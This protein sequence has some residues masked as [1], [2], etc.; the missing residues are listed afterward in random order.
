MRTS[1]PPADIPEE[2]VLDLRAPKAAPGKNRSRPST[3]EPKGGHVDFLSMV[4]KGESALD[5]K[6]KSWFR[7]PAKVRAA[8]TLVAEPTPERVQ[9]VRQVTPEPQPQT[10]GRVALPQTL[11]FAGAV[12]VLVVAVFA[13]RFLGHVQQAKGD[14][15]GASTEAIQRL[16]AAGSAAQALQFGTTKTE[17]TAAQDAFAAAEQDLLDVAGALKNLPGAGAVRS[18]EKLLQAGQAVT[19]AASALADGAAVLTSADDTRTPFV[20]V[21]DQLQTSLTPAVKDLATAAAL[22]QGVRP[23]DLPAD[24]Q[25][26][27]TDLQGELPALQVQF[28]RLAN[29]GGFFQGFLATDGS[30]RRYLFAFQNTNELR[31]TGGF[32]GSVAIVEVT[33]GAITK[34]EVPS[35]GIYD[36]S[37]QTGLRYIA[38]QPLQLVQANWNL[39]DANWFPDFPTSAKKILAFYASTGQPP[40]D[41]IVAVTPAVLQSFLELTGPVEVPE[42][43]L[44]F[45]ADNFVAEVQR[46]IKEAEKKDYT[47]PKL[48]LGYLAPKILARAFTLKQDQLWQL[49]G[50]LQEHLVSRDVQFYFS[51][52]SQQQRNV[53]LGWAGVLRNNPKDFLHIN[54]ANLGGGK[55]DAAIE[56][57]DSHAVTVAAD[58][59]L[60]ATVTVIRKH[61]GIPHDP[62]TG[63]RNVAYLRFYVPPGSA[64]LN[65]SGFERIDPKRFRAPSPDYL[66]DPDVAALENGSTI[67]E[68]SGTRV[69]LE[70]GHT[71]FGNWLG[72]APGE[73][74]KATITYT[75]PFKLNVGGLFNRTDTYSLLAQM[76]PGTH[77][78][79][80]STLTLP[81]AWQSTWSGSTADI[82]EHP[83]DDTYTMAGDLNKDLYYGVVLK[84]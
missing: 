80:T 63:D 29:I 30:T 14:V 47:K 73:V 15:L 50:K 71:V 56:E 51:D 13:A 65:A 72:V 84:K 41:G 11:R 23:Q 62:F 2:N 49:L 64:L 33:N 26:S 3:P 16:L 68:N 61:N 25:A 7:R 17:L 70:A 9:A 48:V 34:I 5:A 31:P 20:R 10:R 46:N 18:A 39:Q 75:L 37:G 6:V 66:P 21:A 81:A 55:T 8:P 38:P 36:L 43:G 19:R 58:G 78:G 12:A 53:N 69:S 77:P 59:T 60:T 28:E 24:Y 45:T 52:A 67:D 76:Q 79:F 27:F 83:A 74:V 1:R 22:L 82:F 40:V 42:V 35:G 57:V 4:E 32:L 44:T 54:R